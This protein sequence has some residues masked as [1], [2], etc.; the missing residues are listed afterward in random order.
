MQILSYF[1]GQTASI[2]LEVTDGYSN[3]RVDTVFTPSVLKIIMPD[4]S[5]SSGYPK[6]MTRLGLG[7]YTFQFIIPSGASS[8]GS[9]LL[10]VS[11]RSPFKAGGNSGD[12]ISYEAY[13]IIVNAPYG[14]FS[15]GL[16]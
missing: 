14:N 7:L 9:Y 4:L 13:Q 6:N 8:I 5:L 16:G 12:D 1:P 10:D 3:V 2:F 15:V 11:Y